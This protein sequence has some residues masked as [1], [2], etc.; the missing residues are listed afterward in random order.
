MLQDENGDALGAGTMYLDYILSS[1]TRL[2][3][4]VD[5]LLDYASPEGRE[6]N[7][8]RI[9]SA[10]LVA[11]IASPDGRTLAFFVR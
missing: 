4:M 2:R 5:N 8:E 11:E 3:T 6:L 1:A 10:Q 7:L 9:N